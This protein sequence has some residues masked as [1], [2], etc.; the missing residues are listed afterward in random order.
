VP[1][2]AVLAAGVWRL[3]QRHEEAVEAQRQQDAEVARQ[4]VDA[5]RQRAWEAEQLRIVAASRQRDEEARQRKEL[6]RQRVPEV[7]AR[8]RDLGRQG[9]FDAALTAMQDLLRE[10]DAPELR[11]TKVDVLNNAG[12]WNEA[13][14]ELKK[15]LAQRP[16]EAYLHTW[17][18]NFALNLEG[19]K[20]AV[21][22]FEQAARLMPS[23]TTYQ[24]ALAGLYVKAGRADEGFALFETI[25]AE[26]SECIDCWFGYGDS[27][28]A[29]GQFER[30]IGLFRKAVEQFPESS[31]HRFLLGFCLDA[32][33]QKTSDRSKQREAATHYRKSLELQPM[34]RSRAAQRILE[35]TGER[36]P[37]ELEAM[38]ADEVELEPHGNV[39]V[40]RAT[41]NGVEGRFILDTGASE[42]CVFSH[43]ARRFQLKSTRRVAEAKTAN[44]RIQAPVLY[45]TVQV[46]KQRQL[47]AVILLLPPGE[48]DG[49]DGLLGSDFM[50]TFGGQIDLPRRRLILR[51][52]RE[53]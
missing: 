18:A 49:I 2:A 35:I 3:W 19:V 1:V 32:V 25:L 34:A 24:T 21:P 40:V 22:H 50:K 13:Y 51:G 6:A 15:L 46:G 20:A 8:A 33:A 26:D 36:V 53:G 30:A 12:R 38:S 16:E 41:I 29:A 4:L 14:L 23:N 47:R 44:G 11:E 9:R 17:A 48:R 42:T 43:T 27:L 52:E 37:P 5:E 10:T 7:Q 31:R 28:F 45:G 39:H